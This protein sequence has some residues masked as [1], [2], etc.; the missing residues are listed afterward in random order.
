MIEENTRS[1]CFLVMTWEKGDNST[2][3]DFFSEKIYIQTS[4][5]GGGL[6]ISKILL[7]KKF[8]KTLKRKMLKLVLKWDFS[9]IALKGN[10]ALIFSECI[11]ITLS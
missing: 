3:S 6:N 5:K 10:G 2:N 4:I 9:V 11:G 7:K 8:L 1:F